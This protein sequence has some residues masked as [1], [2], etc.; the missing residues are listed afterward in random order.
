MGS[1][2]PE[3]APFPPRALRIAL[4]RSLN[5]LCSLRYALC[6]QGSVQF[7]GHGLFTGP[8]ALGASKEGIAARGAMIALTFR[9]GPFDAAFFVPIFG[10]FLPP[11][12]DR[13]FHDLYTRGEEEFFDEIAWPFP[14]L[15]AGG[16]PFG[17]HT[18]PDLADFAE[19]VDFFG[20]VRLQAAKAFGFF[21]LGPVK[22]A[23]H[24]LE[25]FIAIAGGDVNPA[26]P[27]VQPAGRHQIPV[28]EFF[29]GPSFHMAPLD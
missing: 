11:A 26:G 23:H 6:L 27:A 16:I 9:P 4:S 18:A 2:C 24:R 19:P 15:M 3:P 22:T 7:F 14:A 5:S 25:F 17:F 21:R 29:L 13:P 8:A 20:R 10:G 28:P 12:R 1:K